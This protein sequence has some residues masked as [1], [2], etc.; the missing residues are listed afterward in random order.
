MS[1]TVVLVGGLTGE[2]A[3]TKNFKYRSGSNEALIAQVADNAGWN[4]A[5]LNYQDSKVKTPTLARMEIRVAHQL[6]QVISDAQG[7]PILA[8]GSSVGFGVLVGALSRMTKESTSPLALLGFKPL[9][10]PL[11]MIEKQIAHFGI[12]LNAVKAGKIPVPMLL[13]A[14]TD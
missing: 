3:L 5:K 14:Q 9:P 2:Q 8:I 4:F 6:Q 11:K 10:D 7:A 1:G 12:P 13:K